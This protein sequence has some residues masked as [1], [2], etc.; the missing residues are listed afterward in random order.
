MDITYDIVYSK[1]KTISIIVERD[2]RVLVHAPLET[3]EKAIKEIV[4]KKKRLLSKKIEHNQKYPIEKESKEFVSGE[5]LLYL[6]QEYKLLVVDEHHE[7]IVFD[8]KFIINK[9]AQPKANQL[10]KQW[11][12][13]AAMEF[14]LPK[15]K[16]IA[17]QIGVQ[18]NKIR[19]LDLRFR[20]GSCTPK[21]NIHL[22]WRLIKAPVNV[23]EYIIVHELT[24]LVETN[25]TPEFWNRI[26]AQLPNFE[27]AKA[28]LKENG[29][30]LEK[31]F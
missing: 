15:A 13:K 24:H 27:R 26:A 25:H 4:E 11:Y 30:E 22:N 21:N 31:D 19:I 2:R 18:Y 1:R 12:I 20:W 9:G 7:D 16:A 14:I 5:S 10:L 29:H 8:S 6:G 28:W 23:I 3:S 17:K